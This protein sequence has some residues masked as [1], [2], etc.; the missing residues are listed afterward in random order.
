[1]K[2]RLIIL[3][4]VLMEASV[5]MARHRFSFTQYTSD[6]GLSQNS[7]TAIMKDSK[8]YIWLGTRDGLNNSTGIISPFTTRNRKRK[9]RV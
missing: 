2:S 3:L 1:M 8:G 5:L 6:N 7:I 9:I 4:L